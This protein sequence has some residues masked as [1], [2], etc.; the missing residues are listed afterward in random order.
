MSDQQDDAQKTE[1]PTQKRIEQ[2]RKK[3]QVALSR[4][5]NNWIMLLAGTIMVA[6][7]VPHV[8]SSLAQHM[9]H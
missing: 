6:A 8:F 1:E 2:T 4:E 7:I 9:R 5:V 3:G